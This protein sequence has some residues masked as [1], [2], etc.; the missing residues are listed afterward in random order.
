MVPM[1]SA[2]PDPA[3]LITAAVELVTREIAQATRT[4]GRAWVVLSGG[5]TPRAL[6][7]ALAASGSAVSWEK[8]WWCFGDER[9]VPRDD[10]F[11]NFLMVDRVLFSR[12]AIPRTQIVAVP[13]AAADPAAGGRAYERAL[14][15]HVV[16]AEWPA[17][18]VTLMGL[19]ADGHTASLFPGDR[20]LRERTAW[21]T[22]TQAGEPVPDRVTL[23]VPVFSRARMMVFLVTGGSK[24]AAVAATL[25]G[26]SDPIRWPAQGV[27]PHSGRCVWLLD[28]AAAAQLPPGFVRP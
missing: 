16:N 7:T 8:T 9:W 26:A 5:E 20:A 23:T 24:A 25:T 17:F 14:R 12:A 2:Y 13:T 19:G 22:T 21:V 3:A 28:H 27:I 4:R 15:A 6:Y 18:D 1:V 10:P 11:S